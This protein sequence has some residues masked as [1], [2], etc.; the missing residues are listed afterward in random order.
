MSARPSLIVG[1][2]VV[3]G[4]LILAL[5]FGRPAAGQQVV[6]PPAAAGRYQVAVKAGAQNTAVFVIDS[7]T[8]QCWYRDTD[9][10]VKEW[11]DMGIPVA[12]VNK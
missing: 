3:L 6:P 5:P 4:C 8:G 7:T 1:A 9:P 10:Q 2:S 11:T 12:K